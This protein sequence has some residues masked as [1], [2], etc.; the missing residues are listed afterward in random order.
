MTLLIC[1][2]LLVCDN[3]NLRILHIFGRVS[4]TLGGTKGVTCAIIV[5]VVGAKTIDSIMYGDFVLDQRQLRFE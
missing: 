5:E 4:T 2:A 3:G 1:I